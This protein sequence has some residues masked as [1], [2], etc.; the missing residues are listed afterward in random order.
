M[1]S[2]LQNGVYLP[3]LS[4]TPWGDQMNEN[5]SILSETDENNKQLLQQEIDNKVSVNSHTEQTINSDIVLNGNLKTNNV[6]DGSIKH[7]INA[8]HADNANFAVNATNAD[9]ATNAGHANSCDTAN[10]S[11]SARNADHASQADYATDSGSAVNDAAGNVITDTYLTIDAWHNANIP[12]T[13]DLLSLINDHVGN[14]GIH[15]TS[16]DKSDISTNFSTVNNDITN[17]GTDLT[18]LTSRVQTLENYD[19]SVFAKGE[20]VYTKTDSDTKFAKVGS[21]YTTS[22]SD[23]RYPL[24]DDVYTKTHSD[25]KYV[26]LSGDQTIN[27]TKT[28]NKTVNAD[29]SGNAETCTVRFVNAVNNRTDLA[30]MKSVTPPTLQDVFNEWYRFS[31][32]GTNG[33]FNVSNASDNSAVL[34][35]MQGWGYDEN[36]GFIYNTKNTN[37]YVGFISNKKYKN[38]TL[39]T[40]LTAHNGNTD[41]DMLSIICGF[42]TDSQGV[43]HTLSL[44]RT[45]GNDSFIAGGL[46]HFSLIYDLYNPTEVVLKQGGGNLSTHA[47]GTNYAHLKVVREGSTLT[48]YTSEVNQDSLTFSFTYSMPTERGSLSTEA[49]NNICKMLGGKSQIGFG[50]LSQIGDFYLEET[51]GL[52]DSTDIY[53]SENDE[54][55]TYNKSTGEYILTSRKMSDEIPDNSRIY[56]RTL[57]KYYIYCDGELLQIK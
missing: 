53:D 46:A 4:E 54:I 28:F 16:N 29:I 10:Y 56:N 51:E 48:C 36:G 1:G 31:H 21:S 17:L 45:G 40:R 23:E 26:A 50:L 33:Q 9:H 55:Y 18:N 49:F 5:L 2:Y 27:D 38:Y 35:D 42:M 8:D 47:W 15:T 22:D 32:Y 30:T 24:K 57:E 19:H 25:S 13:N 20:D 41:N 44:T 7:A 37:S 43:E 12:S 3:E 11:N 6:I 39:K 34:A 52:F 14:T